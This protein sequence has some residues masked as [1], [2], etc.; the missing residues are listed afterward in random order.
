LAK[1]EKRRKSFKCRRP[2]PDIAPPLREKAQ[3]HTH[4][5]PS[6]YQMSKRF[7]CA[8][9]VTA[10]LATAAGDYDNFK[11]KL[12][13]I[14]ADQLRPG[15]RVE[16]SAREV[17]AYIARE[18]PDGVRNAR[19]EVTAPGVAT[20]TALVD[21]AK[22]RRAQ[23]HPP[24]WLMSK[25]LSGEHPVSVT[26]KIQSAGGSARVD[27]Q[28]VEI[29]GVEIDGGTLDFLIQNCLLPLYPDAKVG[30]PFELGHRVDRLDVEPKGVEVLI[31]R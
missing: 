27:V 1:H 21:F 20:G 10:L 4:F 3:R 11:R 17:N 13:Q 14:E 7:L 30:R 12:D 26:A 5:R 25:F 8:L 16:M 23:G 24:G 15:S 29:S 9:S 28:R 19:V 2:S 18:V 6:K 31:G 22:V